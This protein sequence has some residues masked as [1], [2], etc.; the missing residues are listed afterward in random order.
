MDRDKT[1]KLVQEI[2]TIEHRAGG[3]RR[4]R[5]QLRAHTGLL[6][7][8]FRCVNRGHASTVTAYERVVRNRRR[9]RRRGPLSAQRA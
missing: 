5:S 4:L 6:P 2:V 3:S 1:Y 7:H 9:W 8:A